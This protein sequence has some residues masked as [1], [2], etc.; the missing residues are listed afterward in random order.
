MIKKNSKAAQTPKARGYILKFSIPFIVGLIFVLL[1]AIVANIMSPPEIVFKIIGCIACFIVSYLCAKTVMS[2]FGR[3]GILVG[4]ICGIFVLV[5]LRAVGA[6]FFDGIKFVSPAAFCT[7]VG[8][9]V[10]G[11]SKKG[12]GNKNRSKK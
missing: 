6:I 1:A 5:F 10:A 8:G 12:N 2:A 3:Q 11:L 7:L 4:L 9:L